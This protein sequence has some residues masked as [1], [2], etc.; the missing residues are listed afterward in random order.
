MFISFCINLEHINFYK[1]RF[2]EFSM[3]E[4]ELKRFN[5]GGLV[6]SVA[7][8]MLGAGI[9]LLAT[10]EI[11]AGSAALL[12]SEISGFSRCASEYLGQGSKFGTLAQR[13]AVD[14]MA[15]VAG[16]KAMD[17]ALQLVNYYFVRRK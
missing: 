16:Y 11:W 6:T 9:V 2:C 13:G 8:W 4:E 14:F 5:E 7:T 10:P 1:L 15:F 12:T 17:K 3:T